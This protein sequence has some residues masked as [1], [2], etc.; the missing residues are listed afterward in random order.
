VSYPTHGRNQA[1]E[2]SRRDR[3]LVPDQ[4]KKD[5]E[6]EA[7]K[8]HARQI[9]LMGLTGKIIRQNSKKRSMGQEECQRVLGLILT[10]GR[11]D[12]SAKDR[13]ED[14]K[15][16]EYRQPMKGLLNETKNKDISRNSRTLQNRNQI[17]VGRL[18]ALKKKF[19][20]SGSIR[21]LEKV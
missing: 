7:E 21:G 10:L 8:H 6:G 12:L 16:P 19:V 18:S 3:P 5:R 20:H 11:N 14:K 2:Y 13:G 1:Y 9:V 15:R 4:K 17:S